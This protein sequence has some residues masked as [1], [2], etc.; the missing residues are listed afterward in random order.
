MLRWVTLLAVSGAVAATASAAPPNVVV[1][2]TEYVA[3]RTGDIACVPTA[4]EW[5]ALTVQYDYPVT[6]TGMTWVTAGRV[7]YAPWVCVTLERGIRAPR[8]GEALNTVAHE[9]AHL[10]GL[11]DEAAAACVGLRRALP[12]ATRYYGVKP[13]TRDARKVQAGARR[14]HDRLP[15]AY[16]TVCA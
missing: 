1:D 15:S 5:A 7:R 10:G 16:H 9:G 14:L 6:S 4:D 2:A 12:L 11:R 13:G 3:G 8:I